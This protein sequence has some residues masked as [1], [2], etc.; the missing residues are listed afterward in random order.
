MAAR[1]ASD[2]PRLRPQHRLDES[3]S[4]QWRTRRSNRLVTAPTSQNRHCVGMFRHIASRLELLGHRLSDI[5]DEAAVG[6]DAV[7]ATSL[8]DGVGNDNLSRR[9]FVPL[10]VSSAWP[11]ELGLR[12]ARCADRMDGRANAIPQFGFDGQAASAAGKCSSSGMAGH[13]GHGKE[14]AFGRDMDFAL[15]PE[16]FGGSFDRDYAEKLV[17]EAFDEDTGLKSNKIKGKLSGVQLR[18]LFVLSGSRP[19]HGFPDFNGFPKSESTKTKQQ[20]LASGEEGSEKTE[21][22]LGERACQAKKREDPDVPDM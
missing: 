20:T 7:N 14:G 6:Y 22:E 2:T 18:P 21:G 19:L 11:Y 9:D 15:L 4:Q 17:V 5:A 16:Y 8:S 12:R 3:L 10:P 13:P 1:Y